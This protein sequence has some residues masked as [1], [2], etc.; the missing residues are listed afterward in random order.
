MD[1]VRGAYNT[2]G[3]KYEIKDNLENLDVDGSMVLKFIIK[4]W[5]Q[6]MIQ[7]WT[8]MNLQAQ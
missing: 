1:N 7:L 6:D 3:R 2:L 5:A 8:V 4:K